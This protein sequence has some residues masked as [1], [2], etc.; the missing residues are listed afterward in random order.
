MAICH[1]QVSLP[2]GIVFYK[3]GKGKRMIND[4]SLRYTIFKQTRIVILHYLDFSSQYD[5]KK[6]SFYGDMMRFLIGS[7]SN[8]HQQVKMMW[9]S[10]SPKKMTLFMIAPK[11]WY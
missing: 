7:I 8:I 3:M 5:G 1:S 6:E 2:E 4:C 9:V 11:F 10:V